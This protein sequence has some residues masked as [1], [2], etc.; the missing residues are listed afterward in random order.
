L[1]EAKRDRVPAPDSLVDR[2]LAGL[3]LALVAVGLL[4]GWRPELDLAVTRYVYQ[5]GGFWGA[6]QIA[7]D[8]RDV[9]RL[10][11]H[12]L[13][14]G[15]VALWLGRRLRWSRLP[16]PSGLA[17]A[18]LAA[19][20]TIGPGLIVNLGLKDHSHRPRPVHV[21]EFGGEQ[22]FRPWYRFDGECRK[23][24]AFASG[25]AASGFWMLAP[26][27]L[28]PP[29]WRA[30]AVAGALVYGLAT[31]ALRVAFGGHF[32]SDVLFGGLIAAIVVLA[33]WRRLGRRESGLV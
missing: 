21:V 14:G 29:P 10:A 31:S 25:E 20:L 4:F 12:W 7:R 6:S 8:A 13:L 26:A 18:F 3:V 19:S 2:A 1:I 28:A 9:L 33:L 5:H 11:P 32:L 22:A 16:A 27:L 24:C 30:A 23:N 17:I 15:L